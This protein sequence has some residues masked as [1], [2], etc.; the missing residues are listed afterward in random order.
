MMSDSSGRRVTRARDI[1]LVST[2]DWDNPFWT[3]KQ[4]VAVEL[5][6]QGCKVLYV[7]SSGLRRPS[8]SS[9]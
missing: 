7:E 9:P 8:L 4:H 3:N 2:A 5:A 6:R 1:V